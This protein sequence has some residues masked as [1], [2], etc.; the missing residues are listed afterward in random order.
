MPHSVQTP[1][2]KIY[3]VNPALLFNDNDFDSC[4]K[5]VPLPQRR[6]ILAAKF[7]PQRLERLAGYLLACYALSENAS[8]HE[9]PVYHRDKFGRPSISSLKGDFNIT[10]TDGFAAVAIGTVRLGLDAEKIKQLDGL[11]DLAKKNYTAEEYDFLCAASEEDLTPLFYTLWT[12]KESLLKAVGSGFSISPDSFSLVDSSG[13][14]DHLEFQMNSWRLYRLPDQYGCKISL[15]TE[16]DMIHEF[17]ALTPEE[18]KSAI[19]KLREPKRPELN[20]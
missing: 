5:H 9:F 1:V 8:L 12:A 13:L 17:I 15:C 19:K 6:K 7:N 14:V 11:L 4:I 10:H 3:S 20:E 18:L 16:G 2:V